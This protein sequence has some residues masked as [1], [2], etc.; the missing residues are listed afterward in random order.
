MKRAQA[1]GG[2]LSQFPAALRNLAGVRLLSA[3]GAGGVLYL[4]PLVFHQQQFSAFQVT[5]GVALAALV[6]MGGRLVCGWLL[7][8]GVNCGTPVLLSVLTA[9]A[10][11]GKLF[12]ARDFGGYLLGQLLL[13]TAM[14]L[15]WP[16]IELAVPLS[17]ET[18]SVTIASG[19][20]YALVRSADA[21]GIAS[22]ALLG[23]G[24]SAAGRLRGVYLIDIA[25]CLG[26]ALLLLRRPLAVAPARSHQGESRW[27]AWLPSLLPVLLITLVATSLPALMQSALPLDLVRGGL[28]RPAMTQ[29]L[30]ALLISLQL[31]L[32]VLIQWPVGQS[33]ARR[34]VRLGLSLSLFCFALGAGLLG[35]SS[36]IHSGLWLVLL[37][38]LP[39][40][41]G[42]A[43][44]LPIATQ[45]VVELTP[46]SH[47]GVAMA[48]F[49][50][51]FALSAL[52]APLLGGIA[53]DL[54]QHAAALWLTVA[55]LCLAT[56][57]L[58]R[59]LRSMA[60]D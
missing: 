22:G 32:L 11:D 55:V 3:F 16:A 12:S 14:G 13:G 52:G 45:A 48:L 41:C 30:G 44:F 4:T 49:S 38:Q 51:C 53:L 56:A 31:G 39:L 42:E 15:Y 46:P 27:G 2:W 37:A 54:H 5:L 25:C 18:G 29:S 50:Q 19:R 40:A 28:E 8:A 57:P 21:L 34:P 1:G 59:Q 60:W 35:V 36:Y 23:A 26:I 7:D 43:A 20:G 58:A 9:L 17:C 33:L 24:L 47:R 6:G 10:G